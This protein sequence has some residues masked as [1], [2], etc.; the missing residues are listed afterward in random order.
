MSEKLEAVKVRAGDALGNLS[1]SAT[2]VSISLNLGGR[3]DLGPVIRDYQ[4]VRLAFDA[5]GRCL[6]EMVSTEGS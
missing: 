2:M 4:E 5:L 3:V 6:S 1:L